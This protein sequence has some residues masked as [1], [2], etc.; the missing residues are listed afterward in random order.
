MFSTG[1][2]M[3][4]TSCQSPPRPPSRRLPSVASGERHYDRYLFLWAGSTLNSPVFGPNNG[5]HRRAPASGY[6]PTKLRGNP[7]P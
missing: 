3:Q 2:N 5:V 7:V 1:F 4:F 6:L